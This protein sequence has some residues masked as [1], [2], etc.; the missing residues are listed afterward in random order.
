LP[1]EQL[2]LEWK[3]CGGE[4]GNCQR[5]FFLQVKYISSLLRGKAEFVL[6]DDCR[7]KSTQLQESANLKLLQKIYSPRQI[8]AD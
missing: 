3:G 1:E 7:D 8:K 6:S 2:V 4:G 5:T